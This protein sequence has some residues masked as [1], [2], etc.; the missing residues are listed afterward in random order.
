MLDVSWILKSEYLHVVLVLPFCNINKALWSREAPN[1]HF[2]T[3]GY[4][5]LKKFEWWITEPI[6]IGSGL[7]ATQGNQLNFRECYLNNFIYKNY[8]HGKPL[9]TNYK[10]NFMC[11]IRNLTHF[12]FVKWHRSFLLS[13]AQYVFLYLLHYFHYLINNPKF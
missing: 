7:A 3:F 8:C 12:F 11:T 1:A 4:P 9:N 5:S 13:V 10:V 2:C 6:I